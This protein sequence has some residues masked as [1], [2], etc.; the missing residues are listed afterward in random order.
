GRDE[1]FAVVGNC[2]SD[3][4]FTAGAAPTITGRLAKKS[5]RGNSPRPLRVSIRKSY[6]PFFSPIGAGMLAGGAAAGATGM[7][8]PPQQEVGAGAQQLLTVP[9]QPVDTLP[10]QPPRLRWNNPP[11]V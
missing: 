10:L 11:R 7:T 8:V 5:G 4:P 2:R 3:R 9:Q 1:W 6:D